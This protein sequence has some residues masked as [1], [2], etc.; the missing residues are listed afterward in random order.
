MS[1]EAKLETEVAAF[2]KL[3]KEYSQ[4]VANRQQL[5]SQL[6]E[7]DIVKK[8]FD[9]L[10]SDAAIYKLI[11]PVLVKQERTEAETNVKKRIEFITK[12]IERVEKLIKDLT[13]K[14]EK[15]KMEVIKLQTQ[16]QQS[17]PAK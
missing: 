17:L 16:Y 6:K 13:E 5:E 9:L 4:A 11:G 12:E 15:K 2:T 10:K 8:E 14:Q 7:N 3:Q 1:L